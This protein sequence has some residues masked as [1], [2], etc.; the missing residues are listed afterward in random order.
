MGIIPGAGGTQRTPRIIGVDAAL[1]LIT[2][3]NPVAAAKAHSM[4]LVDHIIN[5]DLLEGAMS[6]AETLIADNAPCKRVSDMTIDPATATDALFD[7]W[8]K[9]MAKNRGVS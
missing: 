1:D 6:Y 9:K 7:S 3:G 8:R 4:G 5:G 2:S